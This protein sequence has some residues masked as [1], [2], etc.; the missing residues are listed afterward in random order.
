MPGMRVEALVLDREHRLLHV[1]RN[2]GE[3]HAPPLLAAAAGHERRQQRRIEL[4]ALYLAC[5]GCP[6]SRESSLPMIRTRMTRGGAGRA[7]PAR[8]TAGMPGNATRT[9][10]PRWP[11]PR[12]VIATALRTMANS[13]GSSA[14]ARCA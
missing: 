5:P 3:R 4:D 8:V 12:G 9:T 1:L 2:R 14:A 6:A 10:L 11:P 7:P 13:P